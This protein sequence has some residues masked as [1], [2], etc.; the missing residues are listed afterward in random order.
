LKTR[1]G[2]GEVVGDRYN[3]DV[4]YP[5]GTVPIATYVFQYRTRS[6][7]KNNAIIVELFTDGD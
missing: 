3:V 5:Y 6:K 1:L 7:S 2:P 4:T